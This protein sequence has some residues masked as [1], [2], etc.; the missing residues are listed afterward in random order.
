MNIVLSAV[1]F[2][3]FL[4]PVVKFGRHSLATWVSDLKIAYYDVQI[5]YYDL[6]IRYRDFRIRQLD[7]QITALEKPLAS[8]AKK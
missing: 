7:K 6:K 1:L 2:E 4:S 5:G 3:R 8:R